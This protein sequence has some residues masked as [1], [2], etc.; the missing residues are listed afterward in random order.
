MDTSNLFRIQLI[1]ITCSYLQINHLL[2]V[3]TLCFRMY[4]V[5]VA[6]TQNKL[7]DL[8]VNLHIIHV[9]LNISLHDM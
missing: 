9:F 7:N 8:T 5:K 1:I 3:G 4:Y 2:Q 6:F